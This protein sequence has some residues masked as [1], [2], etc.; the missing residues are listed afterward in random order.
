MHRCGS[1]FLLT[2]AITFVVALTGCLG[3]SSSNPG[4]GGVTSVTLSPSS[5]FSMDVGGTQVFT[6]TGKNAVG[7]TVLGVNIQFIVTSGSPNASAPLSIA[8]NGN[9]CAGTWDA[10]IAMCSPGTSGIATVAAVINGVSSPLTYVYVHQ[11]IDSIQV[12]RLDPQGP[13]L[14]DCFSQGQTWDYQAVVYSNNVDIT[15]TVGPMS[16]SSSNAGVVTTT[17]IVSATQPNVL[18]QV[19]VTAKA[20]GITQLFASVSGVT[21]NLYPYTTC[22]IQAIYLQIG[23]QGQA[24]N[25]ITV[26][27]GGSV[28]VTA[29]AVDTLYKFTGVTL[30]SPPLTWSTTN[31][32]VAAFSS[33]TNS[34]G[35]NSAATRNN[36]GGATLTASCTPPTCNIG[37]LPSLP[38]YASDGTLPNGTTGYGAIS[39]DVTSTSAVPTYTAW[40]ATTGC[41]NASGCSSALFPVTPGTTPIG[42]ILS[43][44]RTPNS[45]MF[46]HVSSPRVYFGSDQGLMYL[47]VTASS[48]SAALV[49]NS[50]IPCNVSLCGQV[51]TISNDGKLVVVSDTVSTPSQVY[52]YNGSSTSTAPVDL[53]LSVPGET[54]TAAAFSPDQLKLFILTDAGNMYVYSTVDAFTLVP[55][56]TPGNA[57]TFATPANAVNFS[58]DG[59]FA[60][61]AVQPVPT[62]FPATPIPG[63]VSGFA[64]CDTPTSEVEPLSDVSIA[65]PSINANPLALYPLPTLQL[66]SKGNPTEVVLALD[67]PEAQKTPAPPAP[68]PPPTPPT[69]IDMFGV[70]VEQNP[71]PLDQ[72][73]CSPPSVA[74]DANFPQKSFILG[75]GNFNPIYT[76]LV[77]DGTELII[78]ARKL[79]AL[80]LFNVS[81]GTTMS[82][83]LVGNTDPLSAAASTDGSQVYVAACDQYSPDGKTCAA[84]SVHIVCTTACT[85]GQGDYQQVPYVNINDNNNPN[86]CNNQGTNAPLC[87]PNLI[88]IRPQ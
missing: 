30:T 67:T 9:A 69:T 43:L 23:G 63:F 25:S 47:D 34:T 64:N 35:I 3:K 39:V 27:N 40:A 14:Y 8:S 29:T 41:G 51:L 11:H 55:P 15:N 85:K 53:I 1:G 71:L 46:N 19:Q 22:L 76:Q 78:V 86:M 83:P 50:S 68:P 21:S 13:P 65:D 56:L 61:V 80:L 66:D 79:P 6:A 24:G 10:S 42:S 45:M 18:N 4:N 60:Y 54:A 70:N 37:V 74:L 12:S 32:E 17:P 81:N 84:G 82:V 20:P 88:A 52:I 77:A 2:L 49:S 16:W 33:T 87:L 44:P 7:G 48:P 31:P 28:S 62:V 57:T 72:F 26:N 36:L 73:V 75:Q 5:N 38:I 59:S 58:M